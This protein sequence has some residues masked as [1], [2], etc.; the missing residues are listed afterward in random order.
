[1]PIRPI[2]IRQTV[3]RSLAN[4]RQI[5]PGPGRIP[6]A[7]AAQPGTTSAL[8]LENGSYLLLENGSKLLLESS[9]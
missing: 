2:P 6:A 1:M 3:S 7:Q 9:S 5:H 8:L 4:S